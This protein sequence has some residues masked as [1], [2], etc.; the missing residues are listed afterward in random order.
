MSDKIL[1]TLKNLY[2]A[3]NGKKILNG[4]DF[5]IRPGEVQ[6]LLGPNASG[7]STLAQVISG[8][9]KYKIIKGGIFFGQ[10]EITKISP[11]K[12]VK[13]GIALTWQS[14]PAIKG[15]KFS[16]LLEKIS[17]VKF[18][19]EKLDLK[20]RFLERELNLEFSGGEKKISELLQILSLGPKLAIF[21]EIDS[22]LDIKRL[23]KVA[24]II[25]KELVAKGVSVLLITHS[26]VIL[27]FLRPKITNVMLNG[28]IICKEKDYKKVLRTIKKYGYEKCK[29]CKLLAD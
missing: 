8:N 18:E 13:L 24:K 5:Q 17:K 1:L 10:K 28:K 6:A 4:I 15:V 21:D 26:G 12:R 19:S 9:P 22:G 20:P 11:E 29:K 3:G 7:K 2:A 23:E 25:K 16:Q 27:R 14:P